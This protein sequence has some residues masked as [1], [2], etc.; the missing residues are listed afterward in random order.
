MDTAV[1][2][3]AVRARFRLPPDE[4]YLDGNSLGPLCDAAEVEL[5]RTLDEWRTLGIGGWTGGSPPWLEL[6]RRVGAE[7]AKVAAA[8]P[9]NVIAHGSTTLMLHQALATLFHPR[10]GRDKVLVDDL[11]FPTDGYAV[12]SHLRLRGLDPAA[13]VLRAGSRD[14]YNLD[15]EDLIDAMAPDVAVAVLPAVLFGSGQLLDVPRLTAAARERGVVVGW[16]CSHAIGSVPLDLGELDPDFAFWCGYKHLNGG[17]GCVAGAFVSP[18]HLDAP[19]GLAGWFGSSDETMFRME[20]HQT[21]A[22][23]AASWQLGTPHVLSLAPLLG[24]LRLFNEVGLNAVRR[25]SLAL[26]DLLI[27]RADADLET[28][29]FSVITPRH[30]RRRGGHVALRHPDAERFVAALL[31]RGVVTDFRHPDV[32]RVAPVALYNDEAD[33]KRFVHAVQQLA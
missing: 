10:P 16:D 33:V 14:G 18:R 12:A 32:I 3:P 4:V 28:L 11:C 19:P 23:D 5:A 26:T 25:R 29:G 7:Y 8:A 9:R 27:E 31:I 24:S 6:S 21:P 15:E 13:H 22:V 20:R 30:H 1:D 17:P 2:W